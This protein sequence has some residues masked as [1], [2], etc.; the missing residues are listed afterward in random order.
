MPYA[1]VMKAIM[2][3]DDDS[4]NKAYDEVRKTYKRKLRRDHPGW[5]YWPNFWGIGLA[6]LAIHRG[7]KV[8]INDEYIPRDLLI[9]G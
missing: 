1:K 3:L 7:M 8:E 5:D 6:N 2:D 9:K 4:I